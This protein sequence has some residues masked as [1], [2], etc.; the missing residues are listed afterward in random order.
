MDQVD[1]MD[2]GSSGSINGSSGSINGSNHGSNL[3]VL[4]DLMDLEDLEDLTHNFSK[5]NRFPQSLYPLFSFLL[6]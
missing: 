3:V 5:I 6:L 1:L 2:S 4:V